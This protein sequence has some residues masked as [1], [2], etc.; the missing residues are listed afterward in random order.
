MSGQGDGGLPSSTV[1]IYAVGEPEMQAAPVSGLKPEVVGPVQLAEAF[2]FGAASDRQSSCSSDSD[3][4]RPRDIVVPPPPPP[5]PC[6]SKAVLG[7]PTS[8]GFFGWLA[9]RFSSA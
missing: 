6:E 5:T 9:R 2:N 3:D 8:P 1:P 7:P 4:G